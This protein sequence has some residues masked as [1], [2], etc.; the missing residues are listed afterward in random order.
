MSI[1]ESAIERVCAC[2]ENTLIISVNI[3]KFL[4]DQDWILTMQ[5]LT[6]I[7]SFVES[8]ENQERQNKFSK[9]RLIK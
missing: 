6:E 3:E 9:L 1:N 7:F 2:A 8:Q 4:K 5:S